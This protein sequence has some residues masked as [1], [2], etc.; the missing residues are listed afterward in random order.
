MTFSPTRPKYASVGKE[1]ARPRSSAAGCRDVRDAA[2][3]R[4]LGATVP[5]RV[6]TD[7]CDAASE[8]LEPDA[9]AASADAAEGAPPLSLAELRPARRPARGRHG[10]Q[11]L[12]SGSGLMLGPSRVL[13]YAHALYRPSRPAS[14]GPLIG[15]RPP[16]PSTYAETIRGEKPRLTT[17]MPLKLSAHEAAQLGRGRGEAERDFH[18]CRSPR[19]Y[20]ST[21]PRSHGCGWSR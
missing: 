12:R 1:K 9:D 4:Q 21:T 17:S 5:P 14:S 8:P 20:W 15:V 2:A 13:K 6:S 19:S 10:D 18:V 7:V 11:P 16:E 3:L